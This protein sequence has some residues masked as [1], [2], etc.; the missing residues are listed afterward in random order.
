[1]IINIYEYE[2]KENLSWNDQQTYLC[3]Y[4]KNNV[5]IADYDF[6][7]GLKLMLK[8]NKIY[9]YVN[10]FDLIAGTWTFFGILSTIKN[11]ATVLQEQI[12][13]SGESVG[14]AEVRE[15][16]DEHPWRFNHRP[17]E[18]VSVSQ[19]QERISICRECPMFDKRG[20]CQVN[21]MLA[22]ER[23]KMQIGFCPEGK[24]GSQEESAELYRREFVG[25]STVEY[26]LEEQAD[27]DSEL[28][29][30]LKG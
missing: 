26:V 20:V 18:Y 16:S 6:D 22:I 29:E 4:D 13:V 9:V 7:T 2:N 3:V 30:F 19:R 12:E 21:N 27:F 17:G 5:Q 24:W 15:Y 1:M 28:E 23:T 14:T 10:D 25:E 8:D 11:N